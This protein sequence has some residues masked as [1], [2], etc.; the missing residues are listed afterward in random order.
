MIAVNRQN[1]LVRVGAT[2]G[3]IRTVADGAPFD[4]PATVAYRGRTLY[5]TNFAL[6]TAS[7]GKPSAPGLLRVAAL[8]D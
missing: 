8:D 5:A 6:K 2:G 3:A 1:K 7:A 4:F